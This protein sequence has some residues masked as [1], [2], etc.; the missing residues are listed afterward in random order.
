[1]VTDTRSL[2]LDDS[3]E[4]HQAALLGALGQDL[5]P[6]G[7]TGFLVR[8]TRLVLSGADDSGHAYSGRTRPELRVPC[9]RPGKT[10]VVISDNAYVLGA[11]SY[12]IGDLTRDGLAQIAREIF[13]SIR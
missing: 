4:E 13:A 5:E 1:V 10:A 9:G 7:V 8:H 6:H 3:A 12:P 11:D 2:I